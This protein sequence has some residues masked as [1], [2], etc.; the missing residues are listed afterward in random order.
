M[1]PSYGFVSLCDERGLSLLD[2]MKSKFHR[3]DY[4]ISITLIDVTRSSVH[5]SPCAQ[6]GDGD[7]RNGP[8]RRHNALA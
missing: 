7:H 5:F 2:M 6:G 4:F 8:N 1:L 3:L